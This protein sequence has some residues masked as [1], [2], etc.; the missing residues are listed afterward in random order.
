MPVYKTKTLPFAL[1][2]L[3]LGACSHHATHGHGHAHAAGHGHGPH[4]GGAGH[5]AHGPDH[6]ADPA[7]F[8]AQWNDPARDAWQKPAEIVAAMGLQPG[9]T[10][11]DVGAGTGYLLPVLSKAVGPSG[12]VLALD[13]EPAMLT[14]LNRS[15]AEAGW[16]NVRVQ[17]AK[18]SDPGLTAGSVHAAVTLNVWHH[19]D[20]RV[21]YAKQ[22]L[23]GLRPGGSFVVV[24]FLKEQTEGFGPPLAM[25]LSADEV[26]ADLT[27]AGF[28]A[29]ILPETMPRHYVV[30]GRRPAAP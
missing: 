2:A 30:R 28:V 15:V 7:R 24:D 25:R 22:L 1:A 13:I 5:H 4:A 20:D 8:V 18:P 16:N 11:V 12:Q 17:A 23:Q 14:Y 9:D 6:F 27:A 3:S 21:A 10:A 19:V 26:L 29:E